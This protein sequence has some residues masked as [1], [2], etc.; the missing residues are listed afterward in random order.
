[1]IEEAYVLYELNKNTI[2]FEINKEAAQIYKRFHGG[3]CT[4]CDGKDI[5]CSGVQCFTPQR[6]SCW[7]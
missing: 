3:V 4:V 7:N 1:M 5:I 6:L 2:D